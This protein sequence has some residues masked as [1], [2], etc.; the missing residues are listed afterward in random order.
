MTR[1]PSLSGWALALATAAT[2]TAISMSVLAGWQRGGWLAERL[3]WIATGVV[4]V[5]GAHLLPALCRSAP[6]IVRCVGV[7]LWAACMSAASY[8]HATFFLLSQQ[9]AGEARA[10]AVS[11]ANVPPHR[12]LTAVMTERTGVTAALATASAAMARR[13]WRDCAALRVRRVSLI[14]KLDALNAEAAEVRLQQ[15]IEE[16]NAA[17]R[18]TLHDDPVTVRLAVLLAVPPARLDLFAGLAFAAV[19]EGFACLLW[20]IAFRCRMPVATDIPAVME[21]V[22]TGNGT[23]TAYH[24]ASGNPVTP[25]E[26]DVAKLVRDIAAGHLRVTVSDIR[27]HLGCSQAKAA[28]LRRQLV[29]S[30]S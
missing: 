4:L 11:V 24:A 6:L 14:A 2:A 1:R 7:V 10:A 5:I 22:M 27:R 29:E 15:T 20:Y 18:E 9:H 16:R 13:C 26:S 30:R 3:V 12:S 21:P 25:A 17:W 28:A 23:V 19:L 8:G